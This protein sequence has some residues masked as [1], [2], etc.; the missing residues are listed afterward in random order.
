MKILI[1]KVFKSFGFKISNIEEI[2]FN[3][4][5]FMLHQILTKKAE[6]LMG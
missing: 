2:S 1:H 5:V 6:W 4:L 3:Y